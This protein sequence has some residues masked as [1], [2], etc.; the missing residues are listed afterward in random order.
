MVL[1]LDWASHPLVVTSYWWVNH[2]SIKHWDWPWSKI[3]LIAKNKKYSVGIYNFHIWFLFYYKHLAIMVI[4]A[5]CWLCVLYIHMIFTYD[6]CLLTNLNSNT[7]QR[8]WVWRVWGLVPARA[9]IQIS[10]E[11]LDMEATFRSIKLY[12]MGCIQALLS[13]TQF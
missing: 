7:L 5:M 1:K 12:P 8:R 2:S 9:Q 4:S 11:G 13:I 10:L 3:N 6:F